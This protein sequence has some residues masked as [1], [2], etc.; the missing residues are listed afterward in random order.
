M[1]DVRL[2]AARS[3]IDTWYADVGGPL[4]IWKEWAPTVTGQ[5][6]EGGHFFPE[7][8]LGETAAMLRAFLAGEGR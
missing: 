8:R 3:A 2:W 5:V 1:P 6:A 7:A 4:R